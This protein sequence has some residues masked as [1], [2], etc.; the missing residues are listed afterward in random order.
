VPLPRARA[1]TSLA[2][3][4]LKTWLAPRDLAWFRA[5][6]FGRLPFAAPGAAAAAVPLLDW[7]TVDRVLGSE[8]RPLDLMTVA[9]GRLIEAPPP[10]H[11][12]DVARLMRLGVSVVVRGSEAHDD[13]LRALADDFEQTL[14]GETHVQLYVTPGG[15]HSYGWHYDFEDVFIAQTAGVKD[16][17]FRENTV[18]RDAVL[19][20][21]LDF[22]AFRGESS[23]LLSARLVPGDWLYIP[24]TWWHLVKCAEDSLSISVGVMPSE[25]VRRARRLP[26]GWTGARA[27]DGATPSDR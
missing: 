24:A 26:A 10:R 7:D 8:L 11:R 19:G 2:R 18:A 12:D 23:P 5:A 20:D 21:A 27:N 22:G 15:T 16:Y 17:Y 13:R 1:V 14:D 3:A 4:V 25:A 6:H 9:S